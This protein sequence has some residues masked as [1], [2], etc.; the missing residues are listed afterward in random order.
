MTMQ[1]ASFQHWIDFTTGRCSDTHGRHISDIW[2]YQYEQLEIYND[3]IQWLFPTN[4]QSQ[5][6]PT[7][8]MW[9]DALWQNC[10][11][12]T[13]IISSV[14]RSVLTML[15][16]FGIIYRNKKFHLINDP[17]RFKN[18]LVK[19]HHNQMRITRMLTTL[20]LVGEANVAHQLNLFLT[21]HVK[22][23]GFRCQSLQYWQ[24][25]VVNA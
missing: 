8:P 11:N 23:Q 5:I 1:H 10:Q 12:K 21:H 25:A 22:R 20:V 9:D 7:A 2:A 6:N 14:N 3:Y 24:R 4:K 13:H 15:K 17:K 16:Y 19:D 18:W